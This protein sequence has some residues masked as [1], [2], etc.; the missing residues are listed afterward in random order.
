[1]KDI[2]G[3]LLIIIGIPLIAFESAKMLIYIIKKKKDKIQF[4]TNYIYK[5]NKILNF[6]YVT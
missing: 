1:M 4:Y 3:Y 6:L 5:V 2:E